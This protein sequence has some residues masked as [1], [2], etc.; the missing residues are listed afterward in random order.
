MLQYCNTAKRSFDVIRQLTKRK[1]ITIPSNILKHIGSEPGDLFD[2][3]DDGGKIILTP[4]TVE[5]RFTEEEW[6]KLEQIARERGAV[7]KSP[8]KAKEHLKGLTG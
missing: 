4:K 6:S 1:T 7:Y 5:D 2:I 8:A 3:H